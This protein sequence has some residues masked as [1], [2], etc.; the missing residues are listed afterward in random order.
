MNI[1]KIIVRIVL[2]I[3]LWYLFVLLF[4]DR[5]IEYIAAEHGVVY[6][7]IVML[8][9]DDL[10]NRD[11]SNPPIVNNIYVGRIKYLYN[12]KKVKGGII[13]SA[14]PDSWESYNCNFVERVFF[15]RFS[16]TKWFEYQIDTSKNPVVVMARKGPGT[17]FTQ[18]SKD[19]IT[20]TWPK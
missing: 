18:F 17:S 7:N 10:N 11:I 3:V 15:L 2:A 16:K 8:A 5:G 12:A 19:L 4:T 13:V 14:V 9:V 6:S 1:T 20:K